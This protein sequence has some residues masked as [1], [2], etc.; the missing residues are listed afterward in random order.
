MPRQKVIVFVAMWRE[1]NPVTGGA[2]TALVHPNEVA[3]WIKQGWRV[4]D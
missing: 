4:I 1:Y 2:T 3:N